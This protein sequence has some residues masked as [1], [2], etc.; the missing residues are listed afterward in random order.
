[1]PQTAWTAQVCNGD[2]LCIG[3]SLHIISLVSSLAL[4]YA[5][6][7]VMVRNHALAILSLERVSVVAAWNFW[8]HRRGEHT[9]RCGH[10][11]V[12]CHGAWHGDDFALPRLARPNLERERHTDWTDTIRA[13]TTTT[14]GSIMM[15]T[16]VPL[17]SFGH[18]N[19]SHVP[20][21]Q[22]LG[23]MM[24]TDL[25]GAA[26]GFLVLSPAMATILYR[27]GTRVTSR[28]T[29]LREMI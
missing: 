29:A 11:H 13:T 16:L 18:L 15:N 8:I 9:A 25:M 14:G 17:A 26:R 28:P 5:M 3:L 1:M 20:P 19:V 21:N 23:A 27:G 24:C 6:V 7:W 12:F 10:L 4:M 22:R 2:H